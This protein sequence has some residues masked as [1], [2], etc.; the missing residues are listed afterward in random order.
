M[1]LLLILIHS[2]FIL[3][4]HLFGYYLIEG[5]FVIL[6]LFFLLYFSP[7]FF[8]KKSTQSVADLFT[9]EISP[10]KSLM[11]PLV[12]TYVG[13]YLLAFT[14]SGG[15]SQ[16]IHVHL[17]IFIAI[18][19]ILLGYIFA[20]SWKNDVFFDITRF[21]LIFSYITLY[22]IGIYYYFFR[23]ALTLLDP[24]FG[25]VVMGFSYFFFRYEKKIKREAFQ[26][27][28]LSLF[29]FL[30]I[31]LIFFFPS[32]SL[33]AILWIL[34]IVAIFLFEYAREWT[35]FAPFL[36]EARI[37]LL[38]LTLIVS[39]CLSLMIFF[40]FSGIYFL[41]PLLIFFFS[42]HT[43]YSN[44]VAYGGGIFL[45]YFL[46]G[47]LFFSLIS[48]DFLFST[49]VFIYF[50]PLLIII[51]TYFWEER[52]RYDFMII[53]YSSIAFSII[54]FLYSLFFI[55]WQEWRLLF[56]SFAILLLAL[57]FSLS[58]FRFRKV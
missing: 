10:Q 45:L 14:F 18:Y 24:I 49:L 51:N 11:I 44:V 3:T 57:M 1:Y 52:Y 48:P 43:R 21:H 35:F 31:L 15:V 9:F 38:S 17:L 41:I 27:F 29:F 25:T 42:V 46:Y 33:V 36:R 19:A 56:T 58:Y 12:L 32:I 6:L 7:I 16:S 23:D 8:F 4:A 5:V 53:H 20:F 50:F 37:F 55:P 2:V 34:G 40:D 47:H 13:I 30:E 54:F 26:F 39:A 22:S 28:L